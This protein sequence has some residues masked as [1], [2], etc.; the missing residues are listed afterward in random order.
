MIYYDHTTLSRYS[1]RKPDHSR[2]TLKDVAL[3]TGYTAN[4]VSRALRGD[5][6]LPATTRAHICKIADEMGYIP[7]QL[8]STLRSGTSH[9]VA[10]I[11]N[12]IQNSHFAL[13]LGEMEASLREA[14]YSMTILC[15]HQEETL[16]DKMLE[17]A[18]SQRVDGL[19]YF[20]FHSNRR[21]I[22]YLE[23]NHVPFV[24]LDRWIPG[25]FVDTARCDDE[26]G[27]YLAGQRLALLGHRKFLFF[28]GTLNNSS[29]HDRLSGFMRGVSD[30]GIPEENVR[31][32]PDEQ[33]DEAVHTGRLAELL[34]PRDYT[35]IVSFCDEQGYH[36]LQAL[37]NEG[38][39]VPEDVSLISFD[40]IRSGIPFL[41]P[42]SSIA[43]ANEHVA[44]IAVRLL[45]NRMRNPGLPVQIEVLP[46]K[47]YDE[48]TIG[49]APLKNDI[50]K[51]R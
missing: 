50:S 22:D 6:K 4:T 37:Q 45:L 25:V 39:R 42:L 21:H 26:M 30:A 31:I 3:Q 36:I 2:I 48:G 12:D 51:G 18:I 38:I 49:P 47:I 20:P 28:C 46:V 32:F 23:Q 35:A 1:M 11:V 17:V 16:A 29:Q 5:T 14:G 7:N 41:P 24:L 34:Y 9:T 40:H 19:L 44:R 27:G 43:E 13:M 15:T 33:V 10:V 8:A